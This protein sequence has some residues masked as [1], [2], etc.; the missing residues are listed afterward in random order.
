MARA[1]T[2]CASTTKPEP[3][4][5]CHDLRRHYDAPVCQ[6]IPA[7][8]SDDYV[9][10]Q[11]MKAFPSADKAFSS[12]DLDLHDKVVENARC[13]HDKVLRSHQQQVERPPVSGTSRQKAIQSV[14][15]GQSLGNVGT[16]AAV[17]AGVA[18]SESCRG[19]P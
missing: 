11:F 6:N 2:R 19:W 10:Q 17:G 16:G 3:E 15:S 4:Y 13:G 12:A 8:R 9:V 14:R 7:D 18:C 1:D 5:L